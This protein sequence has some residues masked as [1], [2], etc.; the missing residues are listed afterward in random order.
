[1]N[2]YKAIYQ[3]REMLQNLITE[4]A[5]SDSQLT[6]KLKTIDQE[7]NYFLNRGI[8]FKQIVDELDDS[9]FITDKEGNVLYVN[10]A[11]TR[12]TG[13]TPDRVL[14]HNVHDLI[15][16]DK[17]YSGGA[18]PDVLRTKKSAFR[19]S[20]TY[21]TGAPLLGY[22]SGT[23]VFDSDGNL[24]QVIA[25]SRPIVTLQ[26]LKEDFNT[27]VRQVQEMNPQNTNTESEKHLSTEMIGK[28]GTLAN[29][30][31]LISHVAPS[32]ATVLIT[33]ESG[34]GKEVIADEIYRNS[35]RNDKPFVKINCAAIP[36]HLLESELFGYEKGA[37]TGADKNGKMGLFELANT[38]TIFLD[39]VGELPLDMQVKLL[40]VLQEQEFER[41]GGRK[42]VKVDVRVLAATNRDLEEMVKQKTFRQDLY[43]RLMI[44]PVHIPPLRERPDDILPLAQLFLQTLNRKYD[45]KKYLSPLSAKMM[46]DYS[47]PGNIRELRNIIERAVII[48]N[49]DE[50]GPDALHLFT[51][52][53]RPET[54]S[55]V[56]DPVKDL[57]TAMEELELEYI[58]HAYE[59]YGNV[60][61]AAESLGMTPSTFVR[62]RQKYTKNVD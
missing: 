44:F 16:K 55:R 1:M 17:L 2:Q 59:K 11:Y 33:G 36:A 48:S 27:F 21:G 3:I 32:D 45:F 42:P 8:D 54:K 29:I 24:H 14:N 23:P 40:R 62:K 47:W 49:E 22:A 20:T 61:E 34:A 15:E 10:P 5:D 12:N 51:V 58:N 25:S 46:Q 56:L 7:L 39:E 52:E 4:Y 53:D 26:A 50:I 13:I 31:T 41:I 18:I 6:Q 35:K 30:W 43:Y 60:R 28:D 38:G 57:K 37:F 19:L 9:I